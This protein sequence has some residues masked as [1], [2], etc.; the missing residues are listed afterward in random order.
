MPIK[1]KPVSFLLCLWRLPKSPRLLERMR[2]RR[3]PRFRLR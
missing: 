2:W 3:V 1:T